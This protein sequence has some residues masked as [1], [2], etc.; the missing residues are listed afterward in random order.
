MKDVRTYRKRIKVGFEGLVNSVDE[1]IAGLEYA[2]N[3][4]NFAFEKG[5]IN[6]KI[7]I[8]TAGGQF[9]TDM[10]YDTHA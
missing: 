5:V 6:G 9:N 4:K 8:D 10:Y 7:G 3:C 1:S 2:V